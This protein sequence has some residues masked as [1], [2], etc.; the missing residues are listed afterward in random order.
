MS[1]MINHFQK[2]IQNLYQLKENK[3][4]KRYQIRMTKDLQA[5]FL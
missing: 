2:E 3:S 1:P 4:I 5:I